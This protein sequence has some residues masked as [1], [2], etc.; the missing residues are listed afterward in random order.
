VARQR[1]CRERAGGDPAGY[2][3]VMR[4]FEVGE[5]VLYD[6]DVYVISARS[7]APPFRYRLLASRPGGTRFVWADEDRLARMEP[8]LR[9]LDDTSRY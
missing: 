8:Y 3:E 7:P 4:S 5:E 6:G 2:L 9:S 1:D